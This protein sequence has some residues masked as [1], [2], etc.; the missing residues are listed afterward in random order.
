MDLFVTTLKMEPFTIRLHY[1]IVNCLITT[2]KKTNVLL[3]IWPGQDLRVLILTW[4]SYIIPLTSLKVTL[5]SHY[6]S[7]KPVILKIPSDP[8][9]SLR[10]FLQIHFYGG[11][12]QCSRKLSVIF[13]HESFINKICY[14]SWLCMD[15]IAHLSGNL[16]LIFIIH[17]APNAMV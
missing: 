8:D 9:I 16:I 11:Q 14:L 2:H 7:W 3:K 4:A 13:N 10:W 12:W 17:G 1:H 6:F 5:C 15:N